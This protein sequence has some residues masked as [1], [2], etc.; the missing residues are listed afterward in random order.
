MRRQNAARVS[1]GP[2]LAALA[3][4]GL[5]AGCAEM[6]QALDQAVQQSLTGNTPQDRIRRGDYD[7][8]VTTSQLG[9]PDVC[10]HAVPGSGDGDYEPKVAVRI[11]DRSTGRY[12][13]LPYDCAKAAA[14]GQLTKR[15]VLGAPA[16]PTAAATG[17]VPADYRNVQATELAGFFER[18]AQ[19]GGD[20][21]VQWPRVAITLVDAPP[22]HLEATRWAGGAKK[23]PGPACW[24]FKAKV[25]DSATKSHDVE[26][27]YLCNTRD[28]IKFTGGH[29][30]IRYDIWS[31]LVAGPS[32]L[33]STTRGST[34]IVRTEGPVYPDTPLPA[35]V[36]YKRANFGSSWS[37]QVVHAVIDAMRMDYKVEDSRLWV[38]VDPAIAPK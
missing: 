10:V 31:G 30:G 2:L 26:P 20:R 23:A 5:A 13:I 32:T 24:K 18:N 15:P 4:T 28:D 22:W 35:T 16:I 25:W 11:I 17:G 37:G 14:T 19:P 34:G 36:A 33:M 29:D 21:P 3:M 1:A 6:S 27:F 38:N 9:F 8:L 12:G 7:D